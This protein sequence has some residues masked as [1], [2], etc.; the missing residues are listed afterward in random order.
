MV[1]I[2]FVY[3]AV[4]RQVGRR[5][6]GLFLAS[7]W[8]NGLLKE[9]LMMPRPDPALVR[10]MVTEPSPGFPSGH[11]Q[12]A[13]TLWGY[14]ALTYRKPRVVA[15]AVALIV[16]MAVS[17][18]YL[19]VH[20]LGDVLGGLAIGGAL[21]A[22]FVWLTRRPIGVRLTVR[23]RI[24]LAVGIPLLLYPLYQTGTSEQIL[25]FL[26]GF[27]TADLLAGQVVPFRERVRTGQQVAKLAIGYAGFFGLIALHVLYVPV[28]LPAVFGYSLIAIWVVLGAPA[29]FRGLGLDGDAPAARLGQETRSHLRHY[30]ATAAAVL[31]L[32]GG[33]TLYVRQAVPIVER[34]S[35][36]QV[37][38]VMVV[39]HRGARSVAPENTLAS[40]QVALEHGAHLLEMDV[41]RTR[42][43]EVVVVHDDTVDRTTNGSGRV[44]DMTLAE[45][46]TLDAGYRFTP[47]GGRTHPWRGRGVT[48]P[49]LAQVL[50]AFPEAAVLVEIK[51]TTPAM[52]EAVLAVIDAAGARR[53]VMIASFD[54]AVVRRVR[55]LAPEI[56]TS[57][58]QGEVLR[59]VILQR[60]GLAAFVRPAA[61]A[62]QVP[63]WHGLLRVANPGFARLARR[64]GIAFHVWT[65]NDEEAMYRV[66][67]LGANGVI[68]AYPDRLR[69][70]LAVLAGRRLEHVFY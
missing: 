4:D 46:Q 59:L 61:E 32:V 41:W 39:A 2:P 25:G 36:L 6:A 48:I 66:I 45:I 16:L 62:L 57:Y 13:M 40:F 65:I 22:A 15:A 10:H 27:F 68:T 18:I 1:I 5:L 11:A 8:L 44:A 37:D 9:Y 30:L 26:I 60:L 33:S 12:G 42:D 43:G 53:R 23:Q 55:E 67:G 56:P 20:F 14:L 35:I 63:E 38:G 49:T 24:L 31:A 70:V 69:R 47:D 3:W 17:R 28:G 21:V 50:A 34:P 19:G 7:M 52:P 64:Q 54:D 29:L 51:D 58:A